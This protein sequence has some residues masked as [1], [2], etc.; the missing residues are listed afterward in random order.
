MRVEMNHAP[1]GLTERGGRPKGP[2]PALVLLY[3]LA[4]FLFAQVHFQST[5]ESPQATLAALASGRAY[6]RFQRRVLVPLLA[7]ALSDALGLNLRFCFLLIEFAAAVGLLAAYGTFAA[8]FIGDRVG[9]RLSFLLLYPLLWN[10]CVLARQYFPSETPAAL[11][12]VLG[13]NCLMSRRTLWLWLVFGLACL[14]RETS[15]ALALACLVARPAGEPRRTAVARAAGMALVW[16]AARAWLAA[17]FPAPVGVAVWPSRV[18]YNLEFLRALGRLE[19]YARPC[20][21]LFGGAWLAAPFA[22]KRLPRPVK[23]LVLLALPYGLVVFWTDWLWRGESYPELVPIVFAPALFWLR[24]G[25]P[26]WGLRRRAAQSG[27]AGAA[28]PGWSRAFPTIAAWLGAGAAA[29]RIR[30][31][32]WHWMAV[33]VLLAYACVRVHAAATVEFMDNTREA[34]AMGYAP[35][36]FQYRILVPWAAGEISRYAVVNLRTAMNA[37]NTAFVCLLLFAYRSYLTPLTG[38][39]DASRLCFLILWPILFNYAALNRL[40]YPAD[41]P[42]IA[43]FVV[44]AVCLRRRQWALYYAVFCLATFNRETS[45]FLTFLM[46]FTQWRRGRAGRLLAHAA[47]QFAIW[48]AIKVWLAWT[49]RD[50]PGPALFENQ[51]HGNL[52]SVL[53]LLCLRPDALRYLLVF[54][55]A[56]AAVPWALPRLPPFH[57]RALLVAIPFLVGMSIVGN[58]L[59]VR[60]YGELIPLVTA[61]AIVW[62]REKA[63]EG[64]L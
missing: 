56:W 17:S 59:E 4:G 6:P 42:G 12:F 38:R 15:L 54:G 10:S 21:L 39:R 53:R 5:R 58:L 22:W 35:R 23:G 37:V 9:R 13:I 63:R 47:A 11:L 48:A 30:R 49:F 45:C 24:A 36:P 32:P 50:N 64:A 29:E 33:C 2:R 28:A 27:E 1:E 3:L 19:R 43:F 34:L 55:L 57:R 18:A 61:P 46:L 20:L 31:L 60:I 8:R 7:R 44:G 14:N 62:V 41:L 25:L 51:M 16:L 26:A 52:Q 40:Y